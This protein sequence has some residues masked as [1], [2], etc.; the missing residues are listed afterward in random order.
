MLVVG[1]RRRAD[2]NPNA[3]LLRQTQVECIFTEQ[4]RQSTV[5]FVFVI[6]GMSRFS[7][8]TLAVLHLRV[9]TNLPQAACFQRPAYFALF[10]QQQLPLQK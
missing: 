3:V 1:G 9:T 8:R 4:Q 6:V 5:V 7:P 2:D 10:K